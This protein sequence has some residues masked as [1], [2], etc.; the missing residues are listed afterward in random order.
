MIVLSLFDGISCG[1][2]ALGRIKVDVEEY[3]SS[4][5][6]KFA[7]RIANHNYPQDNKNRLGDVQN[8]TYSGADL[9]IGGSP[10][11]DFSFGGKQLGFHQDGKSKLFWEYIR[12]LNI[13]K[14]KYFLLENVKMRKEYRDIISSE[15][16]V[17][18]IEINSALVSAQNRPRLYW[19]NIPNVTQPKDKGITIRD[20]IDNDISN[21]EYVTNFINIHK[22][23][24]YYQYDCNG[25]GHKSYGQRAYPYESKM[26]CLTYSGPHAAKIY[27]NGVVR[28]TTLLEHERLQTLPDYYC[29][30]D[31][32]KINKAK[33]AIGNAWTVD[34]ISHI[35][36]FMEKE[37]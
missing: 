24:N 31:G 34:V 12:I 11:T 23:T 16:G 36:S 2:V 37:K 5:I 22:T 14:P 9:L 25:L 30:V 15:L 4:E 18:P 32:I 7:I 21:Y 28:K 29:H 26:C 35:L 33:Q 19:T 13:C 20:I 17:Q 10:C 1:R 6:D 27:K 3:I 8:V